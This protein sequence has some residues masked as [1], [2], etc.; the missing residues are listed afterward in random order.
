MDFTRSFFVLTLSVLFFDVLEKDPQSFTK[1]PNGF[2]ESSRGQGPGSRRRKVG[3]PDE[4]ISWSW[5]RDWRFCVLG[6]CRGATKAVRKA[7]PINISFLYIYIYISY[8]SIC[9][10]IC[11]HK[12]LEKYRSNAPNQDPWRGTILYIY[13][14]H[15]HGHEF[16]VSLRNQK[17]GGCTYIPPKSCELKVP[18]SN[19]RP[20]T[21]PVQCESRAQLLVPTSLKGFHLILHTIKA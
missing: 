7:V 18:N 4:L 21:E 3:A 10:C 11:N 12:T 1:H 5:P 17:S 15:L 20:N 14:T 16:S 13:I 19:S 8:M 2:L 9:I 6:P